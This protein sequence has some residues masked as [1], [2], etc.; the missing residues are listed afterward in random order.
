[1]SNEAQENGRASDNVERL[2]GCKHDCTGSGLWDNNQ[3]LKCRECGKLTTGIE[4][5]TR[6]FNTDLCSCGG[7]LNDPNQGRVETKHKH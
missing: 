2:V 6:V 4:A 3:T 5:M 7:M 1:M